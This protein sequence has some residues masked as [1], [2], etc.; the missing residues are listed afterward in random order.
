MC[1]AMLLKCEI[2]GMAKKENSLVR[3]PN[4]AQERGGKQ[5][6]GTQ[7]HLKNEGNRYART[8]GVLTRKMEPGRKENEVSGHTNLFLQLLAALLRLHLLA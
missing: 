3:H 4:Q 7:S 1:P 8:R 2:R 5:G 6:T